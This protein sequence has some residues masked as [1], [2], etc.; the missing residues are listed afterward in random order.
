[1]SNNVNLKEIFGKFAGQ[2]LRDPRRLTC[3]M[4]PVLMDMDAAARKNGL[5]LRFLFPGGGATD[6][7]NTKRVNAYA[8]KNPRGGWRVADKF[9]LG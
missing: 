9:D 1:M 4:D 6:D 7:Y 8:E 3:D 5:Q 2:E